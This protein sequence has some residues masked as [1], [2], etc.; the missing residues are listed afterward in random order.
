MDEYVYPRPLSGAALTVAGPVGGPILWWVLV[1]VELVVPVAAV[2]V[3]VRRAG[4][5]VALR[6]GGVGAGIAVVFLG[7][8]RFADLLLSVGGPSLPVYGVGR[9]IAAPALAFAL[10]VLAARLVERRR[11]AG[12]PGPGGAGGPGGAAGV[13]GA[14]GGAERRDG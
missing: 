13:G 1:A 4:V 10:P 8:G 9:W 12:P 14:D 6:V 3:L 7:G 5:S 11:A 2:A